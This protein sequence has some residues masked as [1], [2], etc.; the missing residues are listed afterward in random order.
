M[1]AA[2][3]PNPISDTGCPAGP[4]SIGRLVGATGRGV[5]EIA[6]CDTATTARRALSTTQTQRFTP[7]RSTLFE[8]LFPAL[9]LARTTK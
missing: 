3:L 5:P 2:A 6:N 7:W 1:A 8:S 9:S 4:P